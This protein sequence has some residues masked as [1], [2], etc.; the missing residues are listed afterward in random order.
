LRI[1]PATGKLARAVSVIGRDRSWEPD[2]ELVLAAGQRVRIVDGEGWDYYIE[3]RAGPAISPGGINGTRVETTTKQRMEAEICFQD[4]DSMCAASKALCKEGCDIK[5]L[6]WQ[7][8]VSEETCWIVAGVTTE[9]DESA[10]LTWVDRIVGDHGF[11]VEAGT[12]A[13]DPCCLKAQS[14]TAPSIPAASP[15]SHSCNVDV[16]HGLALLF[17]IGARALPSWDPRTRCA[18]ASYCWCWQMLY[19]GAT[20]A[21]YELW[22]FHRA[23]TVEKLDLE[24]MIA[25]A[26]MRHH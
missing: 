2:H 20:A 26:T 24:D 18:L 16:A 4:A 22:P 12:P 14:L 9:L 11:V 5:V 3:R 6:D 13:T 10:F 17:G 25:L 19:C 23:P 21:Q 7:D 1:R 8:D 15:T